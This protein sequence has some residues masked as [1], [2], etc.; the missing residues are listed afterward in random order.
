MVIRLPICQVISHT[1]NCYV[2]RSKP[3]IKQ[4]VARTERYQSSFFPY[5]ISQ[6]NVLDSNIRNLPTISTFKSAIFK[7]IRPKS[8]SV[9]NVRHHQG[10]IFLTRLRIGFSH[11]REHKF[12]HNFL[13]TT[14]PFC[15]CRT[16]SIETT[17]HYLLRC[18]NFSTYRSVL[19]NDLHSLNLCILPLNASTLSRIL[20]YGDPDIEDDRNRIVLETV[21][22]YILSTSRFSG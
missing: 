9:F 1:R 2:L 5:C 10:A 22:K 3:A 11:L 7:F 17:E 4:L 16:N 6:W 19:F 14:D 12:R 18:S 15:T 13:D 8:S 21:I 20:L